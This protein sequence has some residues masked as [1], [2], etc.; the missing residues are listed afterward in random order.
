[1]FSAM[2]SPVYLGLQLGVFGLVNIYTLCRLFVNAR[3]IQNVF[4]SYE[5]YCKMVEHMACFCIDKKSLFD[6]F[7]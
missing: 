4:R 3:F 1:M 7:G 6:I 2:V 5:V